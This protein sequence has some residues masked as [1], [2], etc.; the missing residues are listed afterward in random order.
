LQLA[1]EQAYSHDNLFSFV[2]DYFDFGDLLGWD[3]GV[4]VSELM[5]SGF[6]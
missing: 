3:K 4:T 5:C 6:A 1:R 2:D